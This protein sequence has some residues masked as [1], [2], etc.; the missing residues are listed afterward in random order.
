MRGVFVT[1]T[2]TGVGKTV[3]AGAACAALA[4]RGAAV[5]AFKPVVTGLE[6]ERGEWPHDHELLAGITGQRPEEVAPYRFGPA[7]SP[8]LAAELAG[9]LVDPPSLVE[10]AR[11][12]AEPVDAVLVLRQTCRRSPRRQLSQR[13]WRPSSDDT[14]DRGST[15]SCH[16]LSLSQGEGVFS[17]SPISASDNPEPIERSNRSTVERL[18]G[19]AVGGL[20]RT[21]PASLASAGAEL[22]LDDW[23]S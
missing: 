8:H 1:G 23:L 7:Y 5:A 6:E 4:E 16:P 3:V 11:A 14:I 18:A 9:E 13:C 21:D 10:R 22:P 19:V 20:P 2:G 15:P 17:I 12:A